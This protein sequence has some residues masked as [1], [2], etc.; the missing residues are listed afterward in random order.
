MT[1]GRLCHVPANLLEWEEAQ[2]KNLH[3]VF[4][5]FQFTALL[6][7]SGIIFGLLLLVHLHQNLP[8]SKD[9]ENILGTI[10]LHDRRHH[11]RRQFSIG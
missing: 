9:V 4:L 11:R 5:K 6:S 7:Q 2:P 1:K 8:Q 10:C 3:V